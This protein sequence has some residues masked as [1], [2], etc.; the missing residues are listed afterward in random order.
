MQ[1]KNIVSFG[2]SWPHGLELVDPQ[3][4][5]NGLSPDDPA[6]DTYRLLNSY[7]GLIASHYGWTLDDRTKVDTRLPDTLLDFSDWLQTS[8]IGEQMQS[9]VL[10]GLTHESGSDT[11]QEDDTFEKVVTTF[12]ALAAHH[13]IPMLQFNV[14]ARQHRMKLPTLIESSSALE[15]LVI[16]NKPRKSPLFAEYKHP[17]EKGHA[18]LSEFLIDKIDSVILNE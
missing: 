16:R 6:N 13:R 5:E 18:I 11:K 1:I 14:L 9:L 8:T 10:I 7:P 2:C 3:L 12:D 17:N 4:K 15:M